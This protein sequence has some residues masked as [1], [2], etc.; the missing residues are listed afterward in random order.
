MARAP[1]YYW[2]PTL[3]ARQALALAIIM[4]A[5]GWKVSERWR[6]GL[7]GLLRV[8][9][10][11]RGFGCFG[12]APHPVFEVTARCNLLCMHCH[13]EGGRGY[14]LGELDAWSFEGD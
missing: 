13:A 3:L 8:A 6:R 5:T 4:D 7:K 2:P 11:A 1:P 12:Y 9:A 10:G 14:P